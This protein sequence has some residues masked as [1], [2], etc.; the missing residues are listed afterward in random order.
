MCHAE[1]KKDNLVC[2][3][4][5][6]DLTRRLQVM[7]E[8]DWQMKKGREL[9]QDLKER[10][11]E[12]ERE[13]VDEWEKQRRKER[14]R[15]R[16]ER[17]RERETARER[18]RELE[19]EREA[20]QQR[21]ND[22]LKEEIW[23]LKRDRKLEDEPSPSKGMVEKEQIGE[24]SKSGEK[25]NNFWDGSDFMM[26]TET[27]FE[28]MQKKMKEIQ[29]VVSGL[30]SAKKNDEQIDIGHDHSTDTVVR[31]TRRASVSASSQGLNESVTFERMKKKMDE[32][33][34]WASLD[35]VWD[36][37][38]ETAGDH[39][40]HAQGEQSLASGWKV[41]EN[42]PKKRVAA[43]HHARAY[44]ADTVAMGMGAVGSE[45]VQRSPFRPIPPPRDP[46]LEKVFGEIDTLQNEWQGPRPRPSAGNLALRLAENTTPQRGEIQLTLSEEDKVI[47]KVPLPPSDGSPAP[48]EAICSTRQPIELPGRYE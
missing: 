34:R 11:L 40:Q 20:E 6:E 41:G 44:R 3:Q 45:I 35:S 36:D 8:K 39:F 48:P 17:E 2:Q 24:A 7:K 28:K 43:R 16:K 12:R 18:E 25:K 10:A 26:A 30:D 22:E 33:S 42:S 21:Q 23:R 37:A 38:E 1:E 9:E 46:R 5:I 15:E 14:D 27:S 29:E 47:S 32:I 31:A 13:K 4:Q 19:R